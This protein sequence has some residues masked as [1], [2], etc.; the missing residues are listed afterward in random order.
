MQSMESILKNISSF[1]PEEAKKSPIKYELIHREE[2]SP[3]LKGKQYNLGIV[4]FSKDRPYQ[5]DQLLSSIEKF[6][7][8]STKTIAVIYKCSNQNILDLY[9]NILQKNKCRSEGIIAVKETDFLFDLKN[10][11]SN[12][13]GKYYCQ[14][15][16]FCVDDL[17]FTGHFCLRSL[18]LTRY[19][20]FSHNG[21]DFII[22]G[23]IVNACKEVNYILTF[24]FYH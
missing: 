17:L 19:F 18:F 2:I 3:D 5:L 12:L 7:D 15:L 22:I 23:I 11:I 8:S 24:Y 14:F 10:T 4:I 16:L 13:K 6:D 1:L 21:N 20:Y 9:L